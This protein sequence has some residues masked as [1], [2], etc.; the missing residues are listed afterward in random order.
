MILVKKRVNIK[1]SQTAFCTKLLIPIWRDERLHGNK[2]NPMKAMALMTTITSQLVGFILIGIFGGMWLDERSHLSPLFLVIGL[3]LGL[4][5]GVY[6][7][8]SLIK[9]YFKENQL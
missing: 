9:R 5:V 4:F 3:L 7:T 6:T 1:T 2:R 8:I